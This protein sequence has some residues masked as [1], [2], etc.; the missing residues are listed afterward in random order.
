[1]DQT[2]NDFNDDLDVQEQ[3]TFEEALAELQEDSDSL[4]SPALI[5]GLSS[6]T[7]EQLQ[8]LGPVWEGLGDD[9]RRI[10]MQMLVDATQANF[11][12]DFR[13]IGRATLT[14]DSPAVR[15]AA[16]E[17]LWEDEST[18][19]L[20]D[21]L[22][23]AQKD[24]VEEV[25]VEAV[26]ALGRFVYLG[27]MGDLRDEASDNVQSVLLNII[28]DDTASANSRRVALES[29]SNCTRKDLPPLIKDAYQS[30]DFDTRRSAIIAMG[31]SCDSRWESEVI[32]QLNNS[33]LDMRLAAIR[34]AGELQ[35]VDA[36]SSLVE[37]L[38]EGEREEQ[39][40]VIWS[41]GEIGG[42]EAMR[43]L[44]TLMEG[45]EEADDAD[46]IERIDDAIG[47]AS[48]AN[49]DFMMVDFGDFTDD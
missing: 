46:L 34:S 20:S 43:I 21:L 19:T 15:Q 28:N 30:K 47:N 9:Y 10:L 31:R 39:G 22:H 11:E 38:T 49:G 14:S 35:L 40:R 33:D 18:A 1:M 13:P 37:N 6:L 29:L 17:M 24:P 4:P 7:D 25:R 44:E 42:K 5:V 12:L 27:E 16:I 45:A 8:Q 3:P 2:F 36:V 26:R 48:L 23:I 32:E 41:L